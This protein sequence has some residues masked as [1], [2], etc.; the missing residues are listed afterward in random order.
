MP[1]KA[2]GNF[3][4][5]GSGH[6]KPIPVVLFDLSG[7]AQPTN[8]RITAALPKPLPTLGSLLQRCHCHRTTATPLLP[9]DLKNNF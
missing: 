1:G 9:I 7:R 4:H 5:S 6:S 8:G 2:M 3:N